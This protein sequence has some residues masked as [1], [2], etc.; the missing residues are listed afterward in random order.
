MAVL[1]AVVHRL[2]AV[3]NAAS[4]RVVWKAVKSGSPADP[5]GASAPTLALISLVRTLLH[6]PI[7]AHTSPSLILKESSALRD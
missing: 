2:L 1:C 7:N 4:S 5:T 6:T 3:Q